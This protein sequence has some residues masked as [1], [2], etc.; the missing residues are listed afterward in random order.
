MS[1]TMASSCA[2]LSFSSRHAWPSAS[3]RQAD[4]GLPH[5]L[6]AAGRSGQFAVGQCGQGLLAQ[7]AARGPAVGIIAGEP[8]ST[9]P[10]GL[11]SAG[12]GDFLACDQQDAQRFP[13]AIGAWRREPVFL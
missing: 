5:D 9:Q 10:I 11:G 6:V 3:A 4:L 13:V 8:Q 1:S 2:R 7:G 12:D